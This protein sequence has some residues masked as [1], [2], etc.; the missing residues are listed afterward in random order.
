MT[1]PD[2][3]SAFEASNPQTPPE[4]LGQI[5]QQRPDLRALV[6]AN[7]STPDSV[8]QWLGSLGDVAVDAAIQNRGGASGAASPY[9]AP[10]AG[11][12]G[13]SA[14]QGFGQPQP[15]QPG[16]GQPQQPGFGQPAQQGYGQ[17]PQ[18]GYG[19]L[20]QQGYGQPQGAYGQ[21]G[22][23]SPWSDQP[24]KSNK[25]PIII[26]ISVGVLI[27]IVVGVLV[28]GNLFS[29]GG[30]GGGEAPPWVEPHD[31]APDAQTYG[32]DPVADQLWDACESGDP[33]ACDNLYAN[34]PVGSEYEQ[35]GADC[36]NRHPGTDQWCNNIE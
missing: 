11:S 19:Q 10:S 27:L 17:P 12:A 9:A 20:P 8:V 28:F 13:G 33:V 36:G 7:P 3:F 24:A 34:S 23:A 16:P 30:G 1:T 29:G 32:D 2:Q 5:A 22:Q 6:A 15:G 14:P 26:G 4:V 21:P 31:I 25:A 18:Q 35:F